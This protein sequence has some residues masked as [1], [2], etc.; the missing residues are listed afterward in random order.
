[1]IIYAETKRQFLEDVDYNRL[2]RRL[3]DGF[4][5]Q[6]GSVPAD[7]DVWADEY[8]RFSGAL[9]RAEVADDMQVAIEYHISA[10]GR[11]RVDV[12][13]VGN[14]GSADNGIVL[15]LKAWTDADASDVP[16]MVMSPYGGGSLSQHPCVQA[17]KYK[18][19]I[20]RFNA[21]IAERKIGIHS[22]AYLFNLDRRS[23]E[24]LESARYRHIIDDTHLFL[25]D[26]ADALSRYI[27]KYVRH[28]AK[29]DVLYLLEKGRL[30]PTPAL[31][32][33]V[34]S[35]LDGNED[36][37]L[38]DT[39]NEAFQIIRHAI[40]GVA[41]AA[42]RQVF[43]VHGGPGT[44]KSVIAVRLLAEVLRS[45]RLGFLV[46]PNKAF[47]DTLAEQ[48]TKRHRDYR[49]DGKALFQS[50]WS[51][52]TSDFTKDKTHEVLIVDEAHRLKD[53]AY[54]YKGK[55]MVDD[56]VRAARISVFFLD[57]TQRVQWN[58]SGSEDRIRQAATKFK[59]RVHEPFRL[60]AQ[61]RCGGSDGYLNWLDDVLQLRPTGNYDNWA[62]EQY[63]F[64]VFDDALALY[65]ALKA[66]N[67][68]NKARLVAGYSWEWP[69]KAGRLR[70]GHL[71]HI[72]VDGLE[73]PW[74]FDRENWAT[75]RDGID[76]V[77]CVHTCQGVEFD[78]LGVLI[79]PDLRYENGRVIGDRAKRAK[80]DN[81]L[82]GS[83]KVL[84]DAKGDA[85]ATQAVLDK[86][87]AII[88]NTYKVLLS[89]G[90]KGCYVWCADSGLREYLRDRLRLASRT[91]SENADR[92]AASRPEAVG[93]R[94]EPTPS[95]K[96]F[97]EWLPVYDLEA[98]AGDFGPSVAADCI[99]WVQ[100]PA[101]MKTDERYFVSQV[102]G[103]SME[104]LIPDGSYCVFRRDVA[105]SRSGKVLLVQHWAISD[106]ETGG[107]Y[108]VKEYRS[109]KV[110]DSEAGSDPGWKH[111]AIQLVPKNKEFRS[112][113]VNPDQAEEV[114]VVAE[115]MGLLSR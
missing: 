60:T 73:L 86:V 18:G 47:R 102:L 89:R 5:R 29:E 57:E 15:E 79:G 23:P 19:L 16:E 81:S 70:L 37:E 39:Q 69:K 77:G 110:E 105:G 99:G 41:T 96:R 72:K 65:R 53:E 100:T 35:M 115:F 113:W 45:K 75:C 40:A 12:L 22:A 25:A 7:R 95:G 64:R 85:A 13:L 34:G 36:F 62:D 17:H 80:T 8:A 20:L 48:L 68:Q 46:A 106:P 33:R 52:H 104:P 71:K 112:I 78:W 87:Q 103:Q 97:V 1:M 14:D 74:N 54:Q 90:R 32:E 2:E 76:Q 56:M 67:T 30:I 38:I 50:S 42:K 31:I 58:D 10:A 114:R 66:K 98:A 44:G 92:S 43:I 4:E 94:I 51:F 11:H 83:G 93:P 24:P 61:F 55:S 91:F 21:D 3:A 9:R 107:S 111:T 108:T 88:K 84:K 63:E 101:G 109:L 28:R 26:D 49:D 59:A 6:T 27:E 82:K